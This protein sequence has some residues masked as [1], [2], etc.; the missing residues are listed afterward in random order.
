M[1]KYLLVLVLATFSCTPNKDTMEIYFFERE[2]SS[3]IQAD[4]NL[5]FSFYGLKKIE[6]T[7]NKTIAKV[8]E[9]MNNLKYAGFDKAIDVRTKVVV[10]KDTLCFDT[11]DNILVNDK[12]V[13]STTSTHLISL[14]KNSIRK[15]KDNAII[16]NKFPEFQFD[17]K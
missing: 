3:Q 9:E 17:N 11:F 5:I 12:L 16:I 15:N 1:K 7:D 6:I 13:D 4:C 2:V 10:N 8:L 14:I